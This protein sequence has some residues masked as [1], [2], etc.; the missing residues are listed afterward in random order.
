M[1]A[2]G[3]GG[4]KGKPAKFSPAPALIGMQPFRHKYPPLPLTGREIPLKPR[5]VG[6]VGW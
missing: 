4:N 2:S 3:K 6:Y 1:A 5:Y